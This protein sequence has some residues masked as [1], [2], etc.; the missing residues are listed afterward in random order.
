MK[1]QLMAHDEGFD[2]EYKIEPSLLNQM[3]PIFILQPLV[4]NAIEHGIDCMRKKEE[5]YPLRF[6]QKIMK[7]YMTV[8]DNGLKLYEKKIGRGKKMSHEEFGYGG[9][10]C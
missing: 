7:L 10:Q 9:K 6:M 5:K 4:E 1:L 2:V 3:V 8:G